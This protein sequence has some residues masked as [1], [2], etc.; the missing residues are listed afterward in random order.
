MSNHRTSTGNERLDNML[1]DLRAILQGCPEGGATTQETYIGIR[2]T[3]STCR[4]KLVDF[5]EKFYKAVSDGD[6]RLS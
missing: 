1:E 6:I 4:S 3:C 5:A 2:P